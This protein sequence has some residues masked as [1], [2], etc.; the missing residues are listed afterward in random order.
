MRVSTMKSAIKNE[1]D[2][3]VR[4]KLMSSSTARSASAKTYKRA[5]YTLSAAWSKRF[6]SAQRG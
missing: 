3:C 2:L 5:V 6:Q 1:T 4:S